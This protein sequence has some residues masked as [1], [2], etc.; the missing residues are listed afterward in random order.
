MSP[1][2]AECDLSELYSLAPTVRQDLRFS[3][4]LAATPIPTALPAADM[5]VEAVLG[6]LSNARLLHPDTDADELL[7]LTASA[8]GELVPAVP[9]PWLALAIERLAEKES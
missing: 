9:D 6:A 2:R 4:T 5:L 3:L 8:L 7:D 1:W